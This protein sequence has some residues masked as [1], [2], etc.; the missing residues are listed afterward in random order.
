MRTAA[1][2]EAACA[3]A[4]VEWAV[5]CM[6]VAEAWAVACASAAAVRDS[7]AL[8]RALAAHALALKQTLAARASVAQ[9]LRI[10]PDAAGD[11]LPRADSV[12]ADSVATGITIEALAAAQALSLG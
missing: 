8:K 5:E 3:E 7:A 9:V 12:K 2:E 1:A 10:S 4:A 11:N 6:S